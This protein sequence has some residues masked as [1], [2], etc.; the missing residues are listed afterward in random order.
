M[1]TPVLITPIGRLTNVVTV[2]FDDGTEGPFLLKKDAA[3]NTFAQLDGARLF[4]YLF[5]PSGGRP[6]P[7]FKDGDI[8]LSSN[9]S[10]EYDAGGPLPIDGGKKV[11]F[12]ACNLCNC[13]T[14]IAPVDC[15]TFQGPFPHQI[16]Q[17][18][19]AK[20]VE[21]QALKLQDAEWLKARVMADY[22]LKVASVGVK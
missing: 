4:F 3:G 10:Q 9:F 15:N 13:K 20:E 19:D 22:N 12:R 21:Y 1:K 11:L 17:P 16:E 8:V 6:C 2:R 7:D 18:V 5:C 14:T